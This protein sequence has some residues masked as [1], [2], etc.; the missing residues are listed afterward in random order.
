[1]AQE[2]TDALHAHGLTWKP[3]SLKIVSW[4]GAEALSFTLNNK[5]KPAYDVPAKSDMKI[6][7]VTIPKDGNLLHEVTCTI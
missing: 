7:G 4:G 5:G 1:M 2:R 6:V 3:A